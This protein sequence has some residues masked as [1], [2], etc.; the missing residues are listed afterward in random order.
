MSEAKKILH[1]ISFT[2]AI[3][4]AVELRSMEAFSY[5]YWVASA[6]CG[7]SGYFFVSQTWRGR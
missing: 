6:L 5:Q 2:V 7:L 3:A 4:S 1:L